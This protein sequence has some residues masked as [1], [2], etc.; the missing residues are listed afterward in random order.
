MN[1]KPVIIKEKLYL[2]KMIVLFVFTLPETP[3]KVGKVHIYIFL[4]IDN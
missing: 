2:R 3:S 1:E 4:L